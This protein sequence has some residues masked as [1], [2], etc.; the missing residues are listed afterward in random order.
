MWYT[1]SIMHKDFYA[2]GFLFHSLSNQVLLQQPESPPDVVVP[3]SLLGGL[4]TD[5]I[6]PETA[7]KN[8]IKTMLGLTLDVVYP[9]YTYGVEAGE[10]AHHIFYGELDQT[11]QFAPKQGM[12]FSWFTFKQVISLNT[13]EQVKHDIVIGQRVID[14]AV[15]QK[16]GQ[17]HVYVPRSETERRPTL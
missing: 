8:T 17:Q 1:D 14:A 16:L 13:S 10:T 6:D 3:W 7:F 9:V 12:T 4:V 15:R 2:N 5:T 11:A